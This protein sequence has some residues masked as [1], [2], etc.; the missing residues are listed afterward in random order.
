MAAIDPLGPFR[1]AGRIA[2]VTGASAGL[3]RRFARGL[4]AAGATVVVAARR[5]GPLV[6][7]AEELGERIVPVPTDVADDGQRQHLVARA[8]EVS[9]GRLDVLVNIAAV[10]WIGP[11]EAESPE[12]WERSVAVNLTAPFRLS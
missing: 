7:L 11:A 6:A 2:I 4:H 9:E 10:S 1:L 8:V 5:E 12:D 3:G